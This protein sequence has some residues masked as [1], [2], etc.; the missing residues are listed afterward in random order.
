MTPVGADDPTSAEHLP[1]YPNAGSV[2]AVD[3]RSPPAGNSGGGGMLDEDAV[4]RS[5]PDADTRTLGKGGFGDRTLSQKADAAE[6]ISEAPVDIDPDIPKR[7]DAVRHQTFAARLVDWR[8]A[9]VDDDDIEAA[10][11]SRERRREAGRAATD[12]DEI[13]GAHHCSRSSS[14]Q[15]PGPIASRIPRLPGLGGAFAI[16]SSRTIRTEGEERLP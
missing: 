13:G 16:T 3:M 1:V 12:D 9:P 8:P 10:P 4:Q 15:K 5:S 6:R 11:A 2:Q 14:E 7:R